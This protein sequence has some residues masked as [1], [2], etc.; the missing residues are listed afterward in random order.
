METDKES[1]DVLLAVQKILFER[2]EIKRVRVEGHTD[3]RGSIA[4]NRKLGAARAA[5]VVKWLV[6]R[7]IAAERLKSVGVGPDRP[8]ESNDSEVGRAANRRLEFHVEDPPP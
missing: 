5:A 8:V 4:G 7:G 2:P 6:A 1:E 3:N